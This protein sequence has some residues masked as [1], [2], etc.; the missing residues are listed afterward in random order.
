MERVHPF[1]CERLQV[2]RRIGLP[3]SVSRMFGDR[4]LMLSQPF[5]LRQQRTAVTWY[6]LVEDLVAG[7]F[8]RRGRRD[9]LRAGR[10]SSR[11]GRGD[12]GIVRC[13]QRARL[14]GA[15]NDPVL[16]VEEIRPL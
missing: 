1:A 15:E 12:L 10:R 7:D 3:S 9:G 16:N 8:F 11:R 6:D 2:G 13:R 4:S 5:W 14:T